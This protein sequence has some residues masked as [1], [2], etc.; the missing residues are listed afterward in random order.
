MAERH[1]SELLGAFFSRQGMVRAVRRAEA[2]VAW[3]RIVGPKLAGMAQAR[4]LKD[5]VLFVDVSDSE[6]AMHMALERPRILEAYE[7]ALGRREIRDVRF[8]AGRKGSSED[9]TNN[10]EDPA[11]SDSSVAIDQEAW[12]ALTSP[13]TEMALPD[14]LESMTIQ[15]ARA[16][17]AHRARAEAAGWRA[18]P[19]CGAW[20]P[21]ELGCDACLRYREQAHVRALSDQFM[22]MPETPA[23]HLSEEEVSVARALAVE[24]LDAMLR[25]LL[26]QVLA[27]P[28]LLP[29]LAV[30]ARNRVALAEG[31]AA[32]SVSDHDL[33]RLDP[34]VARA[35]GRWGGE[36]DAKEDGDA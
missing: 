1:V 19:T 20:S 12:H 15:V 27:S 29:Q 22:V 30:A 34:R 3:P 32:E 4:S 25:R 9:E 18:C 28:S 11:Q 5:G 24:Q 35:L 23:S 26:T 6:T 2:V 21:N 31:I 16:L 7:R 33:M 17:L 36:L 14:D 10:R 13:L 8:V